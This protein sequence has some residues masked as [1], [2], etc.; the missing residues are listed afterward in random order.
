[1]AVSVLWIY[2]FVDGVMSSHNI[3]S[4]LAVFVLKTEIKL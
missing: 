2:G 4:D 3:V 1:M